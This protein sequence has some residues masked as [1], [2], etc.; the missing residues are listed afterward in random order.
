MNITT[1]FETEFV[2]GHSIC[3]GLLFLGHAVAYD[4]FPLYNV[5]IFMLIHIC[6]L[7]YWL[8]SKFCAFMLKQLWK[9]AE[10]LLICDTLC[11]QKVLHVIKFKLQKQANK[12]HSA[13]MINFH[14]WCRDQGFS[15]VNCKGGKVNWG[16]RGRATCRGLVGQSPLMEVRAQKLG[17]WC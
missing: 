17:F 9:Y 5:G 13:R 8:D 15:G 7:I 14:K 11:H 2:G 1:F 12:V 4:W 6:S 3:Q 10:M 16:L